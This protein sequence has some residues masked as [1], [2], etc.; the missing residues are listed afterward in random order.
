MIGTGIFVGIGL[1]AGAS[2]GL[3]IAIGLAA[4]V[5]WINSMGEAQLATP[6]ESFE[7]LM[8]P[9]WLQFAADW[10]LFLAKLTSAATATLGLSGYLLGN[11]HPSAPFWLVPTALLVLWII[12]GIGMRRRLSGRFVI[13]TMPMAVVALVGLILAGLPALRLPVLGQSL[14]ELLSGNLLQATALLTVAYAGYEGLVPQTTLQLSRQGLRATQWAIGLAWL[15]YSG[16][17]VIIVELMGTLVLNSVT[18]ATLSPLIV[19]MQLLSV[20]VGGAVIRLG[21]IAGLAGIVGLLLPK[22]TD[23]LLLITQPL[24]GS[25]TWQLRSTSLNF[26]PQMSWVLITIAISC[27][28]LIGDIQP[29]W[30]FSCVAFLLRYALVHLQALQQSQFRLYWRGWNGLG[31]GICLVLALWIDWSM[32]LVCLGLMSLGLI[33]RGMTQWSQEE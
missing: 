18:Q 10:I 22:L 32:W 14:P 3:V 28:L 11:L 13:L 1:A 12:S 24:D 6:E 16:V 25:E 33:W 17:A 2:P 19:V 7:S 4:L 20:P 21:G 23:R 8:H 31:V 29:I 5:A 30:S 26:S 27:I 15:L 9:S